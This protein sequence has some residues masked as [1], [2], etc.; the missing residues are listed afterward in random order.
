MGLHQPESAPGIVAEQQ[1]VTWEKE[2]VIAEPN[3]T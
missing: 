2:L 1:I 3:G